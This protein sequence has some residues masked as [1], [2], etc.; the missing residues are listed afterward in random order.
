MLIAR[1]P[2]RMSFFGGGTD[3]PQFFLKH[4]GAV[5]GTAIDKYIYHCV[6]EF[7]SRLFDYSIRLAYRKVECV[8]SLDEIEHRPFREVLRF[9][10]IERDV[11]ISLAADLPS[12]SGL[13]S[14]S[15][16]TVGLIN[17]LKAFQG[18]F[19]SQYEL[20]NLAVHIE[21]NIL[22]E[23]VGCQDQVLA[24]YGGLNVVRFIRDD[25]FVVH[26]ITMSQTRQRELDDSLL[27]FFTGVTRPAGDIEKCKLENLSNIQENLKRILNLVDKAHDILTGNEP[28]SAFGE[29][30][31]RT[32]QEKRML[33]SGVSKPVIDKMYEDGRA[34]GALGG[35]LLGAG[36]GGFLLFFVPQENQ[37]AVRNALANYYEIPFSINASGS[38]IIHS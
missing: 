21:R 10:N 2:L 37:A 18:R 6:T 23:E 5:L 15:S 24:A 35:K 9:L 22:K 36:G 26:R 12:S 4:G 14:S 30:L 16:F 28:L 25:H 13:G 20:A 31:D 27:M 19:I 1:T 8:R 17:A 34:A 11:E 3:F 32:W 7:P 33:A 38:G 29:L